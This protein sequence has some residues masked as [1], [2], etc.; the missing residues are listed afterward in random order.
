MVPV[1]EK[2]VGGGELR[3]FR[4]GFPRAELARQCCVALTR[5]MFEALAIFDFQLPANIADQSGFL[6]HAC[7]DGHAGSSSAKHVR[8]K[9]LRKRNH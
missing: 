9:F 6:Q 4:F 8:E 2:S 3:L 7:G 5:R 1:E